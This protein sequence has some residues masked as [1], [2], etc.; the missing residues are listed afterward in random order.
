MITVSA[1]LDH[2]FGLIQPLDIEEVPLTAAF[3]RVLARP[4]IALRDQPPFAASA[5]DG[6]AIRAADARSRAKLV[7]AGQSVAGRAAG[8]ALL[9]GQAFRIFTGA[10]LPDGADCVVIQEDVEATGDTVSLGPVAA[11]FG[12]GANVR[13]IGNDFASGAELSAPRRLSAADIALLAAMHQPRIP[14][15]RRPDV[16]LIA[17]GDEL[18]TPG[19][20]PGNDQI[21]ASNSYG[22][23]AMLTGLGARPRLLP[24][25]PD[26]LS[27]LDQAFSLAR[28]ADLIVTIGGASVGDHDLVALAATHA[29]LDLAFHKVAMRPGKPLMAGRLHGA[30]LLGLPGNPVSAMVCG[31]VFLGPMIRVLTGLPAAPAPRRTATL[32][33]PLPPNGPREHY[34]RA[35]RQ[36]DAVA[37]FARQDSSLLTLL[38][39]ADCLI[40]QPTSDPARPAGASVEVIDLT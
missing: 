7:V 12:P 25:A 6:Y 19:D 40:V 35:R 11:G 26:N 34:L 5:M 13:P 32:A 14:V 24:I 1:A 36:G 39:E 20:P 28:G 3:G 15:F 30:A 27:A 17:T 16:A 8:H 9:P 33:S 4:V 2:L 31:H 18:V 23:H 10:P 29:G 38:A 21:A 22:L 37:A